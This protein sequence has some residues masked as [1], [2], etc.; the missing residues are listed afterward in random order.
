MQYL[1][2]IAIVLLVGFLI[3]FINDRLGKK[4]ES[5]LKKLTMDDIREFHIFPDYPKSHPYECS[6]TLEKPEEFHY[7]VRGY[8]DKDQIREVPIDGDKVIWKHTEG[9]GRFK[10][11][12]N[13]KTGFYTGKSIDYIA[14]RPAV[15]TK[16][17][18]IFVSAHYREFTDATWIKILN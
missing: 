5:K 18:W 6:A 8:T 4:E 3:K 2:L 14:P 12:R 15:Y 9:N 13:L 1:Y 7:I 10:G 11:N 16:E 17:K